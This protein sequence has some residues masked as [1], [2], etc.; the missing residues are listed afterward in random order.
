MVFCLVNLGDKR[1]VHE[2]ETEALRETGKPDL[3]V[4]DATQK[5]LAS[6]M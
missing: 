2:H 4:I 1:I 5:K 6:K 3:V